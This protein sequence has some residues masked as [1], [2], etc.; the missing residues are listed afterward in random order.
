MLREA[1]AAIAVCLAA[2]ASEPSAAA[3]E[4][5]GL[6]LR[7]KPG[8]VAPPPPP[9]Y[10]SVTGAPSTEELATDGVATLDQGPQTQTPNRRKAG[11]GSLET[12]AGND[13]LLKELLEDKTIPLF[14]FRVESPF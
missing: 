13:E 12:L 5:P 4:L 10:R 14:R 8:D 3:Q 2:T 9:P 6:D 11:T 7:L 1:L